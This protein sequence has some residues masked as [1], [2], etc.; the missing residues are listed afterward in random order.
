DIVALFQH[1][2]YAGV[3]RDQ[4][5]R[6]RGNL[7]SD[8]LMGQLAQEFGR[9]TGRSGAFLLVY[10]SRIADLYRIATQGTGVLP[11]GDIHPDLA[12]RLAEEAARCS[13]YILQMCIRALD[14]C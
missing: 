2:S 1:F 12:A 10:Q 4:I 8:N 9:A 14:Y 3:L 5:A 7:E 13:Q 6:T 11:E